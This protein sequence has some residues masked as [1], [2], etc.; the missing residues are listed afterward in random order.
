MSTELADC[1]V[2]TIAHRLGTIMEY[3]NILVFN[4]GE[5]AEFGTPQSLLELKDGLFSSL[6][7]ELSASNLT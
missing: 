6:T 2:I 7:R 5:V 1:T 3:D 4:E